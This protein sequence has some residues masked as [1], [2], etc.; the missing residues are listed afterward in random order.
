[1][2]SNATKVTERGTVSLSASRQSTDSAERVVFRVSDTGIGMTGDQ[3]G[4]L[5]QSFSQADVLN[6]PRLVLPPRVV[7]S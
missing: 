2:L 7:G 5:F 3:M 6:P 1:L 4:K